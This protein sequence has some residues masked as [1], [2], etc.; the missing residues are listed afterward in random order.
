M[1]K[2]KVGIW[3]GIMR[4][5]EISEY[6]RKMLPIVEEYLDTVH[7]VWIE[8]ISVHLRISY[9]RMALGEKLMPTKDPDFLDILETLREVDFR[10]SSQLNFAG[11]VEPPESARTAHQKIVEG[12][13]LQK[14]GFEEVK[15]GLKEGIAGGILRGDA[16]VQA[17]I[18]DICEATALLVELE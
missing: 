16:K 8:K 13:S 18:Y 5:D 4:D 2:S 9:R 6:A 1:V 12:F 15:G 3:G 17:G 7:T 11:K 10:L 14:K